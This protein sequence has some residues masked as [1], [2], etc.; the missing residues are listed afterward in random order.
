VTTPKQAKL[1][2]KGTVA[3]GSGPAGGYLRFFH[4]V[5]LFADDAVVSFFFLLNRGWN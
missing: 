4:F 5:F 1:E 3:N 2:G